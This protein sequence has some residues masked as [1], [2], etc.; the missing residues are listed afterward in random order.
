MSGRTGL[1]TFWVL[2]VVLGTLA[3]GSTVAAQPE[4]ATVCHRTGSSV[5]PFV[6]IH[7]SVSGAYNGHLKHTEDVIPLF[8]YQGDEYSLNWPSSEVEV[9]DG[10]C[11]LA[12]GEEEEPPEIEPGPPI[13]EEP[14]EIEPGPP[15]EEEP[16]FTG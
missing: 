8:E 1:R 14:P 12:P 9:V 3:I 10:E 4:H 7:P 6:T 15:I 5:H 11:V 2:A 16:P 13:E